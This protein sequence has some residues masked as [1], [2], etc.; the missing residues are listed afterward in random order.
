MKADDGSLGKD[1]GECIGVY[2]NVW[3]LN[4]AIS[5]F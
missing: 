3:M 1:V 2:M 5:S 4:K